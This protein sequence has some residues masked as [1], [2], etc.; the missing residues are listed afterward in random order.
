MLR[1]VISHPNEE[2]SCPS[3]SKS[4]PRPRRRGGPRGGLSAYL[5]DALIGETLAVELVERAITEIKGTPL[6]AFLTLLS[7]ELEEDRE[8]LVRLMREIGVRRKRVRVVPARFAEK[9]AR[10]RLRPSS[11]PRLLGELESL[12]RRIDGK[13]D[14]WNA[15]RSSV[16]ARVDGIDVDELIRRTERQAEEL[17]RRRVDHAHTHGGHHEHR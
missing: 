7:W 2:A 8:S 16:G 11:P 17:E 6:G 12:Q 10:L 4:Q 14:M 15:L 1:V 9:L 3:R 5:N 13:L